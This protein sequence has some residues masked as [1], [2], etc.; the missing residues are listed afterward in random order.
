MAGGQQKSREHSK[1]AHGL[2][3]SG[4]GGNRTRVRRPVNE[5]FYMF[6]RL[7][8]LTRATSTDKGRHAPACSISPAIPRHNRKPATVVS[9]V[10][11]RVARWRRACRLIN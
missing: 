1:N 4:D 9:P 6:S 11:N 7:I 10:L 8:V 5:N 3:V 2:Y